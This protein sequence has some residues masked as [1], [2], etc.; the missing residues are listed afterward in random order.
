M[1]HVAIIRLSIAIAHHLKALLTRVVITPAI[2]VPL[3]LGSRWRGICSTPRFSCLTVTSCE[4]A[5]AWAVLN[6]SRVGNFRWTSDAISDLGGSKLLKD[7]E[8][9]AEFDAL[10]ASHVN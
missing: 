7:N 8:S 6:C 9:G 3:V 5:A 10:L 2:L 4:W 1:S